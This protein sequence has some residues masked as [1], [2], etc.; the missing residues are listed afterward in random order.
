MVELVTVE[1]INI[2]LRLSLA[3]DDERLPDVELRLAQSQS[4]VLRYLKAQTDPD[5]TAETAPFE[6]SAAIILGVKSLMDEEKSDM[7]ARL[8]TG[9]PGPDNPIGSLLYP[10]RDPAL[11]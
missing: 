9:I 6:V 4:A 11:A 10:L 1:Q 8:S 2:A 7:L 5:W 3:D